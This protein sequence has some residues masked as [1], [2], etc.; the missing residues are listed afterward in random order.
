MKTLDLKKIRKLTGLKAS[1][2]AAQLFPDHKNAYNAL[3]Y[4]ESGKGF[5]DSNQIAKLSEIIDVPIGLLFD[6]A[7]WE[8]GRPAGAPRGTLQF[9]AYDYIAELNTQ[10]MV[11]VV[12]RNGV[13]VIDEVQHNGLVEISDYLSSITDL[14]ISKHNQK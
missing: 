1:E 5:L 2:L 12:Y 14:L 8:M 9:K 3:N 6:D 11:T 4:V 13:V 10:T 7:A